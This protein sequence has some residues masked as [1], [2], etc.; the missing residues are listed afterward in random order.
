MGL[1][2]NKIETVMLYQKSRLQLVDTVN[3][4]QNIGNTVTRYR[5]LQSDISN[6]YWKLLAV[7]NL[8][9]L[10]FCQKSA[11]LRVKGEEKEETLLKRKMCCAL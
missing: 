10:K 6:V 1:S 11:G 4:E 2:C 8:F 7:I 9:W 5:I 3:V